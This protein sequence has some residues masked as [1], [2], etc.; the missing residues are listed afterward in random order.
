MINY[1]NPTLQG[2][3]QDIEAEVQDCATKI[4]DY[5]FEMV[6]QCGELSIATETSPDSLKDPDRASLADLIC[7]S[8]EKEEDLL[9]LKVSTN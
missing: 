5:L 6:R 8:T 4:I 1:I 7:L 3:E 2:C 9:N